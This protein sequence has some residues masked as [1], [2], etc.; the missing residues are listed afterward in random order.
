MANDYF[1][2]GWVS[3]LPLP[4]G[5]K[6]PPPEGWT[7]ANAS[8]PD[9]AQVE[10]WMAGR[11]SNG[12][13]ALRL[14]DNVIAIDVDTAHGGK[15]GADDLTAYERF[16]KAAFPAT[17]SSSARDDGSRQMFYRVPAGRFWPGGLPSIGAD[18]KPSGK[19][20]DVQVIH[21]GY[22]YSVVW[23]SV[24]P[25][26]GTQYRWRDPEGNE[27]LTPPR[28]DDLTEL[29]S[30]LV[31]ALA[32]PEPQVSEKGSEAAARRLLE[33]IDRERVNG[34]MS[35]RVSEQ[36]RVATDDMSSGARHDATTGNVLEL[37]RLGEKGSFGAS[38]A[39]DMLRAAFISAVRDRAGE[40]DAAREFDAMVTSAAQRVVGA[41]SVEGV[42][43]TSRRW[44]RGLQLAG[45]ALAP[46]G[47][48]HKDTPYRGINRET[49]RKKGLL[50][51]S[52]EAAEVAERSS[53]APVDM[54]AAL[55]G[56]EDDAPTVLSRTD[57]VCLF[58]AGKVHSVHGE[59]ESGKSWLVQCA[60]AEC[61]M[62]GKPVLYM[63]FEADA[64][65][66]GRRLLLLGVPAELLSDPAMFAYIQPDRSLKAPQD[67]EAFGA[68]LSRS[69]G[70]TVVDGVTDSMG[71]FGYS[72]NENDDVAKWQR[73][74]PKLL[75]RKTGA[76][77]VCVDHVTKG[78]DGRGRYAIGGQHKMAGLDGA[79]FT[80]E[81]TEPFAKGLAGKA[82]V[83][84]GKDRPGRLRGLA[85]GWRASDRTQLIA[86]FRLD[87]TDPEQAG[88]TLEV[89]EQNAG[90]SA[91]SGRSAGRDRVE[92]ILK[93][94]PFE[95]TKTQLAEKVGGNRAAAFRAIDGLQAEFRVTC[96][97]LPKLEG[98]REVTRELWGM[99]ETP[100][101][102]SKE[103]L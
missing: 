28:V 10:R 101:R 11:N 39:L 98:T 27:S 34:P 12:N 21:R 65:S 43:V 72:V 69:F 87:S 77:V 75:A 90:D 66:V 6:F 82:T 51:E 94:H 33:V 95:L 7:G 93:D 45:T 14:N 24:H 3:P 85:V 44:R 59:S 31:E 26:T 83:R 13:V 49:L 91:T 2:R 20:S 68:S 9:R 64:R 86:E 70:L 81:V 54:A 53:W 36:L 8:F 61:L 38:V 18:G 80:V 17:W 4:V 48:W 22:R 78:S 46:G 1:V 30:L 99:C 84:V 35:E 23:P 19:K 56:D 96:K 60:A 103:S 89:P 42:D 88:W 74:L 76:A 79:A 40:H 52:G 16:A 71:M 41:P 25:E 63:D 58:Y 92:Q 15:R 29:P 55:D 100:G 32:A 47:L 102:I 73:E 5:A 97:A 37:V 57:A 62:D 67:R 50:D